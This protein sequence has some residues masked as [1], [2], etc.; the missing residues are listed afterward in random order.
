M[1]SCKPLISRRSR[2]PERPRSWDWESDEIIEFRVLR[3]M[4]EQKWSPAP[5]RMMT[6]ALGFWSREDR[7]LGNSEKKSRDRALRREGRFRLRWNTEE[8]GVF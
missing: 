4:P 7:A 6:L 5:E 8:L 3:S 2:S 1:E